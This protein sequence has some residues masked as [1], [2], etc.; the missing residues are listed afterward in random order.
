MLPAAL[1][2]LSFPAVPSSPRP[3][4]PPLGMPCPPGSGRLCDFGA[5]GESARQ[6][7]A[8]ETS[9]PT[10]PTPASPSRSPRAWAPAASE[11][12]CASTARTASTTPSASTS[13]RQA[14][15]VPGGG[16]APS[17]AQQDGRG[18]SEER[19]PQSIHVHSRWLDV[20]ETQT[21]S[22]GHLGQAGWSRARLISRCHIDYNS[23]GLTG[24]LRQPHV[25]LF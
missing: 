16:G 21:Q 13:S 25:C 15:H 8:A 20:T 12:L 14:P 9:P 7:G 1:L 18:G 23:L 10:P 2:C 22:F 6:R 17:Q 5:P 24:Q 4:A 19:A 3:R 11:S